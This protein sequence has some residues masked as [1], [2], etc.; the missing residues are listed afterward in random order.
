MSAKA[1]TLRKRVHSEA[2]AHM[3]GVRMK[4]VKSFIAKTE[5]QKAR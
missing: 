5:K 1:Q 3:R 4:F 2:Q